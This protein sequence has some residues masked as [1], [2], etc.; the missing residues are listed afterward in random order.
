M[1]DMHRAR[2]LSCDLLKEGWEVEVLTPGLSYQQSVWIE[3]ESKSLLPEGVKIHEAPQW[4]AGVFRWLGMRTVG[5]RAFWPMYR[6]GCRLLADRHFDVVYFSTT[7]VVLF[8]LGAL[9]SRKFAI[10][11]ILDYHDPWVQ[12]RVSYTNTKHWLKLRIVTLL[13]RWL[14]KFVI[15]KA[16]GVVSVSPVYIE[17]LRARYGTVPCL[18][19][20][21]CEAIPFAGRGEDFLK[22]NRPPKSEV[23]VGRE[24]IY[25]GVGGEIMAKS[26]AAICSA[27][28]VV[29]GSH[30]ML[31]EGL[32][33]RL[34]GTHAY[35][36]DGD[37][38]LLQEI[39][40]HH[41]LGDVVVE[42]PSRIA[43]L[44]AME[45]VQ[46]SDGLLILGVDDEGYVPSKLFTFALSGKPLL[47]CF[48]CDSP[49]ARFFDEM[50]GLGHLM[51]F[52]TGRS[53]M[54][55]ESMST[56]QQFLSEV[57]LGKMIDRHA[58]VE[59]YLNPSM[60][61]KHAALFERV[62]GGEVPR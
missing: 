37:A 9:W 10:P 35:W 34:L 3:P 2:M 30:P 5:L 7:Q 56:M 42:L 57:S 50:P 24:I 28:A 39:A 46:R 58:L 33:V 36:Q 51:T 61:R 22:L 47:A 18:K 41:G 12:D 23:G 25:V 32:K 43:Y 4:C 14:E 15:Q 53:E 55:N 59:N 38:K 11:Y 48:R 45:L 62:C 60:A 16:A 49:A 31:F 8:C 52:E 26:F 20:G 1:A 17:N 40:G 27:M 54:Q 6:L 13:S 21:C 44:K 19:D 29:R